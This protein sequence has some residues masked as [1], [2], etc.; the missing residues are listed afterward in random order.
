[1]PIN[2]IGP[3]NS[4]AGRCK[5][6]RQTILDAPRPRAKQRGYGSGP[7][8]CR[9]VVKIALTKAQPLLEH[10]RVAALDLRAELNQT[11]AK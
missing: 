7:Q 9:A 4:H 3:N 5:R 11:P 10:P 6:C 8:I 2:V 1:M